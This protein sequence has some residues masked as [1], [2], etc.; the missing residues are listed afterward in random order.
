VLTVPNPSKQYPEKLRRI[1]YRDPETGK[2]LVL[3]TNDLLL[4]PPG[5]HGVVR[6]PPPRNG[7]AKLVAARC[8]RAG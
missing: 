7:G 2:N 3:L 1:R 5:V 8:G 6:D 4:A